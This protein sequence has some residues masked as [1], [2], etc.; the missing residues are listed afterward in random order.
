MSTLKG[1]LIRLVLTVTPTH[2]GLG[3]RALGLG[4]R[5][6]AQY[7]FLSMIPKCELLNCNPS[8]GHMDGYIVVVRVRESWGLHLTR[9]GP[10]SRPYKT[11]GP[12]F[13]GRGSR[14]VACS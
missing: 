8:E 5:D 11:W 14:N 2:R 12:G 7:S 3:F 10:V 6:T 4:F 13:L 1:P 9:G